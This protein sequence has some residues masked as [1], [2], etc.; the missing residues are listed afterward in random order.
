MRRDGAAMANGWAPMIAGGCFQSTLLAPW[1]RP[2]LGSSGLMRE[3]CESCLPA[4]TLDRLD[5]LRLDNS[6][7]VTF[8]FSFTSMLWCAFV[9]SSVPGVSVFEQV[10]LDGM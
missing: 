7:S 2:G 6:L 10:W 1:S 4:E 5:R 3:F 9:H 8:V